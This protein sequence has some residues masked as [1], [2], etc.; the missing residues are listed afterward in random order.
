M[1]IIPVIIDTREQTPWCFD[2]TQVSASI[3]TLRTGDYALAGDDGFCI[4]RKTLDDFL[5]TVSSGWGRFVKE[6]ER[7]REK[8][9]LM[10]IIV[11][12]SLS[13][14]CFGQTPDVSPNH[15]HPNLSPGF[16]MKRV[17]ECAMQGGAVMW[18]ENADYASGVAT[19]MLRERWFFLRG[20]HDW[21]KVLENHRGNK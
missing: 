2:P 18:C 11:E 21:K 5:G 20:E 3:G 1:E 4:E 19:V 13:D 8:M 7:A 9:P 10:P 14:C 12:G 17:A 16:V 15:N 6:L